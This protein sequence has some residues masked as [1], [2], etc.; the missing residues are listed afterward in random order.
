ME[1]VARVWSRLF[2]FRFKHVC[3]NHF[4]VFLVRPTPVPPVP[5]VPPG[6][7]F[8]SVQSRS[9]RELVPAIVSAEQGSFLDVGEE[10]L[11]MQHELA[12]LAERDVVV[13]C[14]REPKRDI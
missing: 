6:S 10:F 5:P 1:R 12:P 4:C 8:C 9:E 7:S 11:E 13:A 3:S 2:C 14:L